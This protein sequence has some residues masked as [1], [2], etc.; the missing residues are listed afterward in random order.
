MGSST[1][2]KELMRNSFAR[3]I[4]RLYRYGKGSKTEH[5]RRTLQK[6]I[7]VIADYNWKYYGSG[8]HPFSHDC[9]YLTSFKLFRDHYIPTPEER[10][11]DVKEWYPQ[12]D[13]PKALKEFEDYLGY[14]WMI[15]LIMR[16]MR[17][18][19][20]WPVLRSYT[21]RTVNSFARESVPWRN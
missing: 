11:S 16:L 13:A 15:R 20:I 14:W 7:Q 3:R 21:T 12:W 4:Q 6:C 1:A 2:F 10:K 17:C 19:F 9:D 18:P 5:A 8:F